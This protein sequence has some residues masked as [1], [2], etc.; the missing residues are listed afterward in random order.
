MNNHLI[1]ILGFLHPL[2]HLGFGIEFN[3]PAIIAEGLAQAAVH[4]TWIRPLFLESERTARESSN[5]SKTLVQLLQEIQADKELVSAPQ[6]EDANKIRDGIL[7]RAPN[8]MLKYASQ[9]SVKEE[10]LEEKT[11][12]MINFAG[13]VKFPRECNLK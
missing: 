6:F 7:K 8:Q 12:E 3:Q 5:P 11:A 1:V 2:I 9:Y 13:K 10:Q 4:S